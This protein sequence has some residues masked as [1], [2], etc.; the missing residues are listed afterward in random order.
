MYLCGLCQNKQ[1]FKEQ[2]LEEIELTLSA[3]GEVLAASD[4]VVVWEAIIC[5]NCGA[6]SEDG[7][8]L[9]PETLEPIDRGQE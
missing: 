7:H 3:D 4:A 2:H 8:I 6:S 1:D 9:D 5:G